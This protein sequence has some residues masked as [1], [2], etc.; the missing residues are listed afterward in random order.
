MT[1]YGK[2][3]Y[4]CNKLFRVDEWF[5]TANDNKSFCKPCIL[6]KVRCGGC[7]ETPKI[8]EIKKGEDIPELN[9]WVKNLK[10]VADGSGEKQLCPK[11]YKERQGEKCPKCGKTLF[12]SEPCFCDM[13]DL[14]KCL[15]CGKFFRG[16]TEEC[17]DCAGN[18]DKPN[19]PDKKEPPKDRKPKPDEVCEKC[20]ASCIVHQTKTSY[21][22]KRKRYIK[23]KPTSLAKVLFDLALT[24]LVPK[25]T[26]KPTSKLVLS[27]RKENFLIWKEVD[28]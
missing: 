13:N 5:V 23:H 24:V 8:G 2:R 14:D 6:D 11:C 28:Y 15:K 27:V 18:R 9:E 12:G 20:G 19:I 25:N 4:K 1:E 3:C 16:G 21:T 7:F 22:I 26:E 10:K 17:L